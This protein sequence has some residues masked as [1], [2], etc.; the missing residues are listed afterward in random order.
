MVNDGAGI[1]EEDLNNGV[2]LMPM[3][4]CSAIHQFLLQKNETAI[5]NGQPDSIWKQMISQPIE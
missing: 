1:E 3:D 2:E 5:L 4:A